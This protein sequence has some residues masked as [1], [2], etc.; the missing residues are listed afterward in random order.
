MSL[1]NLTLL[2]S[3]ESKLNK[4]LASLSAIG[5]EEQKALTLFCLILALSRTGAREIMLG[6]YKHY[7]QIQTNNTEQSL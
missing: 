6:D 3:E 1:E 2:H 5:L 4:V 7:Y